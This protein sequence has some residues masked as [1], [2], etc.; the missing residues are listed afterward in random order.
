M[1]II[2]IYVYIYMYIYMYICI[3]IYIYVYICIYMLLKQGPNVSHAPDLQI[4]N[5]HAH[6]LEFLN[7]LH[8][9]ARS[10]HTSVCVSRSVYTSV[11]VS[12]SVYTSADICMCQQICI[13]IC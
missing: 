12:R 8:A 1:H 7:F 6:G 11:C 10:A 13:H 9:P 4:R 3:Y 5:S 2:Y